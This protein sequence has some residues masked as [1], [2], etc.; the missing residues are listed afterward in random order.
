MAIRVYNQRLLLILNRIRNKPSSFLEI[1]TYL[2]NHQDLTGDFLDISHRTFQRDLKDIYSI[3]GVEIKFGKREGV[4]SIVEDEE[5]KPF[6]RIIEAFETMNAL[7][8]SSKI[9]NKVL[10]E[11]KANNGTKYMHDVLHAIEHHL[12]IEFIHHSFWKDKPKLRRVKPLAI[13]ESQHRWYLICFDIDN[14]DFRNFGLDRVLKL[15][16][17][18]KKFKPLTVDFDAMYQHAFGVETYEPAEHV[19]LSF[20]SDQAKYIKSL[21]LHASQEILSEENDRCR[22]AYFIHPTNDF[23]ME[24]LKHGDSVIVEAPDALRERVK[25]NITKMMALYQNL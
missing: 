24:L 13:K 17:T 2:Q 9:G 11:R 5:Q 6:E 16:I 20:T 3:Y 18:E 14:N 15:D 19:V 22:F 12:E 7:N 1:K 25:E 4:Y 23:I 21:P 8:F 10:V